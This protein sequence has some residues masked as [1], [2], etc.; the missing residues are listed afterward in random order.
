MK[1]LNDPSIPNSRR[2]GLTPY[3]VGT[4]EEPIYHQAPL[5]LRYLESAG[6]TLVQIPDSDQHIPDSAVQDKLRV[7]EIISSLGVFDEVMVSNYV[8]PEDDGGQCIGV[9]TR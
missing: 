1:Y 4:S 5:K 2:S 8:T 9:F 3:N 6:F 7:A